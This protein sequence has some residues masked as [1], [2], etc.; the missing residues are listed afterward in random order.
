[1]Y[2]DTFKGQDSEILGWMF[3][4]G[5]C[6]FKDFKYCLMMFAMTTSF[7]YQCTILLSLSL[8]MVTCVVGNGHDARCCAC[9]WSASTRQQERSQYHIW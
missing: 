6:V 2:I 5:A 9:L 8:S 1:M 3:V 4:G 7:I